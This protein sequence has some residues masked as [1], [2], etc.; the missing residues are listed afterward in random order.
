MALNQQMGPGETVLAHVF[1]IS[2]F[3]VFMCSHPVQ[4]RLHALAMQVEQNFEFLAYYYSAFAGEHV[5]HMTMF[6]AC[7]TT[8]VLQYDIRLFVN[9][10]VYVL[11]RF[12]TYQQ[13]PVVIIYKHLFPQ[14]T[15]EVLCWVIGG[16]KP[17]SNLFFECSGRTSCIRWLAPTDSLKGQFER[18]SKRTVIIIFSL[19]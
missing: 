2:H 4:I 7:K 19:K 6:K 18:R 17:V 9:P 11:H 10:R 8:P 16:S 13:K 1:A 5:P 15:S 3:V 12:D 14:T